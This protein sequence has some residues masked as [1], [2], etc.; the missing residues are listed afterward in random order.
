M[1]IPRWLMICFCPLSIVNLWMAA[2]YA[3]PTGNRDLW[4][5]FFLIFAGIF[6]GGMIFARIED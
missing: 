2:S 4:V 1:T 3:P 6:I 5:F